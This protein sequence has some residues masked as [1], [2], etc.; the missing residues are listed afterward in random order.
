MMNFSVSA[1]GAWL[2]SFVSHF[3]SWGVSLAPRRSLHRGSCQALRPCGNAL[4]RQS[5]H[6]GESCARSTPRRS[7]RQRRERSRKGCPNASAR[8]SHA[9]CGRVPQVRRCSASSTTFIS[10]NCHASSSLPTSG[11]RPV[12]DSTENG[13]QSS[14]STLPSARSLPSVTRLRTSARSIPIAFSAP[15]S[16]AP[17]C[18][19]CC[20]V[21][22]PEER[23][24]GASLR[25]VDAAQ[26]AA[27]VAGQG[28][29]RG[30]GELEGPA[31]D[32]ERPL[33]SAAGPA[34][35][36]ED[37]PD[38]RARGEAEHQV[39][40]Q[41]A[42][43]PLAGEL[44]LPGEEAGRDDRQGRDGRHG[45]VPVGRRGESGA[46]PPARHGVEGDGGKVEGDREMDQ[47]DV[48]RMFGEQGR[49]GVERVQ[50]RL[51]VYRTMTSP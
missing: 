6:C 22:L 45:K 39:L 44:E 11:K 10:V 7:A 30:G 34:M 31:V 29:Q 14:D 18:W 27:Q 16:P 19:R 1:E 8:A 21:Q 36:P 42:L 32:G 47:D 2:T 43:E 41:H 24:T 9:R 51:L 49:P 33:R 50:G 35:Y 48:L 46:P 38:E 40:E 3:A 15:A 23:A 37:R 12:T 28:D 4:L 26:E 20:V 5:G 25:E 13:M 17:T